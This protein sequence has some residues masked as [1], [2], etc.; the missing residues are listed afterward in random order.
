MMRPEA[1]P[2]FLNIFSGQGQCVAPTNLYAAASGYGCWAY[3][4]LLWYEDARVIETNTFFK[5]YNHY[6]LRPC[7]FKAGKHTYGPAFLQLQTIREHLH[8]E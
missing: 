5:M 2:L 3:I 4:P 7:K 1:G 8:I 6:Y